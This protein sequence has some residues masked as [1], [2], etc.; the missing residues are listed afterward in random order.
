MQNNYGHGWELLYNGTGTLASGKG[1][2]KELLIRAFSF[3][4]L[5]MLEDEL[6]PDVWQKFSQLMG[7][8][9]GEPAV[10]NEGSIEATVNT[11]PEDRAAEIASE[12]FD[13]F[14]AVS[15]INWR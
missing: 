4:L 3:G 10:G 12:V 6:P 2:I 1:P 9:T 5:G 13:M 15:R 8:V 11:L 14:V 7:E